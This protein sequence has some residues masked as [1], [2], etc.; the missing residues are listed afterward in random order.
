MTT[1][2]ENLRRADVTL[3]QLASNGGLLS[4]EQTSTFFD[5]VV[6]EPTILNQI[7]RVDM[8]TSEQRINKIG[9]GGRLLHGA[10]QTGGQEDNGTNGRYLAKN[11]RAAPTTSQIV[12]NT[13]EVIAEMRIPYEVL[14]DNIE[15]QNYEQ[16]MMRLMAQRGA[17]DLEELCLFGDKTIDPAVDD[18]LCLQDGFIKRATAHQVDNAA[19]GP[20]DDM[21]TQALL[22]MPQQYLRYLPQM[23]A[24]ISQANKIKFQASRIKRNT[25]LGDASVVG[26]LNLISQGLQI[27]PAPSLAADGSGTKGLITFP[28]NLIIGFQRQITLEYD[29]DIRSREYIIVLTMRIALQ[30]EDSNA[31]VLL[32][33]I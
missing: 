2:N 11:K 6:D 16:H 32:K 8:A 26:N 33:N 28:Q 23:R 31:L 7:R 22:A 19:A 18:F 14:E 15:G 13:R 12:M 5:L 25:A 1:A 24:W 10:S 3:A 27:E 4:P 17:L 30:V 9:L 21:I 20:D 29:K